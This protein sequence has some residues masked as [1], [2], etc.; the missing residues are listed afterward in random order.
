MCSKKANQRKSVNNLCLEVRSWF[1]DNSSSLSLI[2]LSK[3]FPSSSLRAK[4]HVEKRVRFLRRR[5]ATLAVP[6]Q[7]ASC[8]AVGRTDEL[9]HDLTSATITV[10]PINC[11]SSFHWSNRI[12]KQKFG[13]LIAFGWT[14]EILAPWSFFN[15][16]TQANEKKT[17]PMVKNE[18][19]NAN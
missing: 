15:L 6:C 9:S 7:L 11:T 13:N 5:S 10:F 14:V 1:R 19:L 17:H 12:L 2:Q 3:S 16:K 4:F 18:V 8:S